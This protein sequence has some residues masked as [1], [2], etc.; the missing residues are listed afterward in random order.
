MKKFIAMGCVG[1]LVLGAVILLLTGIGIYNGLVKRSAAVDAQWAVVQSKYQRRADLIPNLV[2]TVQG[3]ANFEKSTLT[4]I[5]DARASVGRVTIDASKAP[6]DAA[7]LAEFQKAQGQLSQAL[8]RL[9]MV[10]ENYPQLKA[11]ENFRDLTAELAGT[12]N[13]ISVERDRYNDVVRDFNVAVQTFPRV[14]FAGM[15]GFKTK[16]YFQA[17]TEAQTAPRVNFD[18]STPKK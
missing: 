5:A 2:Q 13:R 6:E 8:S 14:L 4:E 15:M 3:A 9:L 12:E 18:F 1:V 7:K 16:P 10:T 11:N 17:T